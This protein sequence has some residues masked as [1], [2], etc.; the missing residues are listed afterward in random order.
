M[1]C[2]AKVIFYDERFILTFGIQDKTKNISPS[3]LAMVYRQLQGEIKK[4]DS[5]MAVPQGQTS[6]GEIGPIEHLDVLD[7]SVSTS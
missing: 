5:Q 7:T 4:L 2:V 3:G 6:P 1:L